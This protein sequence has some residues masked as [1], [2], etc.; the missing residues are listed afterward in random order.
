MSRRCKGC[1]FGIYQ[2]SGRRLGYQGDFISDDRYIT[3]YV[4]YVC[5]NCGDKTQWGESFKVEHLEDAI[6]QAKASI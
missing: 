4:E 3:I 2:V 6:K 5:P 1:K